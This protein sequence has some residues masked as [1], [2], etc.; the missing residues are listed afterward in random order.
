MPKLT[1]ISFPLCPFVQRAVIALKEK[2]AE[3]DVAYVDLT[4]KPDWFL[5]LSPLG[6][7]PVLKVDRRGEEPA[8]IFESQVI[9]EYLEETVGG[10]KLHPEDALERAQH[11]SWI[12]YGSQLMG[13][14]WK[15]STAGNLEDLD[16]AAATLRARFGPLEARVAGPLFAG[17]HF[18][19]VDAAFA[20]GFR[21]IDTIET[22]SPT[23]LFD[24]FPK[25][26]A[27]R[28]ALSGRQSV[29]EAVPANFVD[30]CL[31]RFRE[32]GSVLAGN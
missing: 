30:L 13:E 26:D 28:R 24:E 17:E 25:L 16:A 4:E 14:L 20:P 32:A 3:F 15:F 6:K 11:R 12:E 19:L 21:M 22:V 18:S 2:G 9:V 8:A 5:A 29:K 23:N 1:L 27:W 7:V 31:A 10:P